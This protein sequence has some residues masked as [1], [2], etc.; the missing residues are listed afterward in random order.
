[1]WVDIEEF[2]EAFRR[3]EAI[4]EPNTGNDAAPPALDDWLACIRTCED[5]RD[6]DEDPADDPMA[7]RGGR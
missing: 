1:M 5:F 2:R 4:F 6:E 3:A 7:G